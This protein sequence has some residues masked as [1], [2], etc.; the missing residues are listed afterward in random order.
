MCCRKKNKTIHSIWDSN[1]TDRGSNYGE[2]GVDLPEI[3]EVNLPKYSIDG[4]FSVISKGNVDKVKE[5]LDNGLDIECRNSEGDTPLIWASIYGQ[6]EVVDLLLKHGANPD[7]ESNLYCIIPLIK[8]S[9]RGY[10]EIVDLLL[11]HGANPNIKDKYGETSIYMASRYGY[12]DIV[13][14]LLKYGANPNVKDEDG[15]TPLKI[16][17]SKGYK[18]IVTLLKNFGAKE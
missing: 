7:V 11:K 13:D 17:S 8:A 10:K 4:F 3:K 6:S 14:L 1:D 2:L 16:A 9:A 15:E 5:Y 18:D 12:K